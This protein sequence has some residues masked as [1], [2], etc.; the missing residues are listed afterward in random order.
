MNTLATAAIVSC[1]LFCAVLLGM[2]V[3]RRLP[4]HHLNADT[5]D[6]VK[7]AMGL[8]ATMSALLL[9]LLVS[10]AKGSYDTTRGQ[11]IQM[12]AKVAFLDRVLGLYGP[13]AAP[14]QFHFHAAV[15]KATRQIWS[16]NQGAS[17]SNVHEGDALYTAIQGLSP[18]DDAQRSLK[19]QALSLAV[20]LAQ[21]RTL[22]HAQSLASISRPLL[23]VVV[24]WLV[25]IFFSF[26][27]LAPPNATATLALM[28]SAL[29]VAG[30]IFLILEMDRPFTGL[31]RISSEPMQNAL[32]PLS[33]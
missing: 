4:Q 8:V 14:L 2:W 17:S 24:L 19:T 11:V 16:P 23:V 26:S 21:L 13:E 31:V 30:A 27:L 29:A 18:R 10:S 20:D 1:C 25:I 12:A 32:K 22:L 33:P 28:V 9:G 3:R 6:T 7:L 5:K 15:E